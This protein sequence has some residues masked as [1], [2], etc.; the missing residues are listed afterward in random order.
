MITIA[1]RFTFDAAHQLTNL[2]ENHKCHRLHGHTYEVELVLRGIPKD[3]FVM[4]YADIADAWRPIHDALDHRFLNDIEGL[5]IPSTEN[6]VI[7][8]FRKFSEF[9]KRDWDPLHVELWGKLERIRIKESTRT[10]CEMTMPEYMAFYGP[11][12]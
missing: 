9:G 2:P 11:N 1:K 6:I 8:M 5:E 12:A 10:W 7:W 4:D 3:G